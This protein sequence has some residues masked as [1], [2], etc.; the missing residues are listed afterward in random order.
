[1]RRMLWVVVALI[2][3]A[4]ALLGVYSY[5]TTRLVDSQGQVVNLKSMQGKWL[6]VNYWA[7]WCQPCL[8]ELP[9]LS[10]LAKAYPQQVAVL[11]VNFDRMP[12]D[13][14]NHFAQ[15]YDIQF[16]LV[17]EFPLEHYGLKQVQTLPTTLVISPQGKLVDVLVG[18]QTRVGLEERL[19]LGVN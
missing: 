19:R 12:S 11:G 2:L 13:E 17:R 7:T 10:A 18:P 8:T 14:I 3:I 9:E 16:P 5:K 15:R 4:A 6:I 1:M